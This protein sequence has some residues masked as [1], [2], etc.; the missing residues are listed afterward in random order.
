MTTGDPFSDAIM[1]I[2]EQM[3]IVAV[4]LIM[5]RWQ[6]TEH[7]KSVQFYRDE[8]QKTQAWIRD[9]LTRLLDR[10]GIKQQE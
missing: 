4:V 1:K 10:I 7:Q 3:P 2:L 6:T 8:Q 5:F 9:N